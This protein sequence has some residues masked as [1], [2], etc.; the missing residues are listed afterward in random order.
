MT[1]L[2]PSHNNL[3][4]CRRCIG[5]LNPKASNSKPKQTSTINLQ[6]RR[7][8]IRDEYRPVRHMD[9]LHH[10]FRRKFGKKNHTRTSSLGRCQHL[11][12][13]P[14]RV[15]GRGVAAGCLP[16]QKSTQ[17]CRTQS[18]CCRSIVPKTNPATST[19]GHGLATS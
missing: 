7:N 5:F 18:F 11:A 10:N 3:K 4:S 16:S 2:P 15:R 19:A 13:S 1:S 6:E 8:A 17:S 14:C 12:A 9:Q